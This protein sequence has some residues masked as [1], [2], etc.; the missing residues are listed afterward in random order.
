[1]RSCSVLR[2]LERDRI[3]VDRLQELASLLGKLGELQRQDHTS[4]GGLGLAIDDLGLQLL[5]EPLNPRWRELDP[6]VEVLVERLGVGELG[7][8]AN[9]RFGI[10]SISLSVGL[11]V[12]SRTS[13]GE[14]TAPRWRTF[15]LSQLVVWTGVAW[16]SY[17][18]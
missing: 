5:G 13:S 2:S 3:R 7:V 15:L 16:R 14:G 1:M 11:G 10:S 18:S 17:P 9:L 6:P 8:R 4:L 12:A